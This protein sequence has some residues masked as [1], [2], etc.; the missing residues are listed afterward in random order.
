[1]VNSALPASGSGVDVAGL[2]MADGG[3]PG[4][5]STVNALPLYSS[6]PTMFTTVCPLV[7]SSAAPPVCPFVLTDRT[8]G[9]ASQ[10]GTQQ[11]EPA[12]N[13]SGN[14]MPGSRKGRGVPGSTP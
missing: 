8:S 4:S 9:F 2:S 5:V 14:W 7:T 3:L 13:G 11:G 1:M 6:G 12:G 10:R